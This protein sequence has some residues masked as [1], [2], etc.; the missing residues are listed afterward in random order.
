MELKQAME[1]ATADL[2]VRPGFVGDVMTGARRRHT[3]RLVAVTAAVALLAGVTTGVLVTRS[4]EPVTPASSDARFTR[5][6][7][8]DLA[9]DTQFIEQTRAAWANKTVGWGPYD[10]VTDFTAQS[11]VFWAGNT[12]SGPAALVV[13]GVMVRDNAVP[14]VA[15]GLVAGGAVVERE[16]VSGEQRGLFQFGA[17]SSTYVALSLGKRIYLSQDP[18]RGQDNRLTRQW[19]ELERGEF[20]VAV[21]HAP[22]Q[23]KPVFV[24]ADSPPAPDVFAVN[25]VRTKADLGL[26]KAFTPR[27]G[28]GWTGDQCKKVTAPRNLHSPA[29]AQSEMQARAYVDFL[30]SRDSLG[31]WVACTWTPDGRYAL[32]FEAFGQ[33]YGALYTAD[34]DF[35]AAIIGGPAV[36]G[37]VAPVRLALP[38]SQGTMVADFGALVGPEQR[39]DFWLAP[40]G[41]KEVTIVR[42]DSSTVVP[43]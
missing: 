21:V 5:P 34:G 37:T 18:V 17:D 33:V 36:K 22:P 2:D 23:S 24:R 13:Q 14:Q 6:T 15:V 35:S 39:P 20:G 3:R 8:G 29:Q 32:A 31:S 28:L 4:S 19:R 26:G 11:N 43:L 27:T 42:G 41:T 9:G 16:L 10:N 12:P 1:A 38:D 40:A 30:V 7:S 25:P